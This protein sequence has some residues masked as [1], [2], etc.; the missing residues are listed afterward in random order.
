MQ[1]IKEK[2]PDHSDTD[3]SFILLDEAIDQA[4]R[5]GFVYETYLEDIESILGE[6]RV[7]YEG[8]RLGK[9]PDIVA[10][11]RNKL[12]EIGLERLPSRV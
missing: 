4:A 8:N 7:D 2:G 11:L 12:T 1:N 5:R 9:E 6:T 3:R 10:E